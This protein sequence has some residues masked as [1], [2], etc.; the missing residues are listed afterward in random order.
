MP[1]SALI[2]PQLR[3]A[4]SIRLS[5]SCIQVLVLRLCLLHLI[6]ILRS[7]VESRFLETSTIQ[8]TAAVIYTTHAAHFAHAI[9]CVICVFCLWVSY[10][11]S[12]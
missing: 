3:P 7:A 12:Q 9:I 10:F 8:G 1:Y 2:S 5:G 11:V 4:L 6:R